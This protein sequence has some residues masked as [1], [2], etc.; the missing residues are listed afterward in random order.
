MK[1]RRESCPS[2]S[3]VVT[4]TENWNKKSKQDEG[5][6][7]GEGGRA[8]TTRPSMYKEIEKKY[9]DQRYKLFSKF[10]EGILLDEGKEHSYYCY[11]Y[12]SISQ[13]FYCS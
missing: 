4:E 9:W 3:S 13:Y 11:Y 1:R 6:G 12:W 10:D 7:D 8:S 5:R 2:P